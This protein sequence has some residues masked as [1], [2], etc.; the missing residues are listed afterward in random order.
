[1]KHAIVYLLL[2][3]LTQQAFSQVSGKLANV[4]GQ[5]IHLA[6]VALLKSQDSV[7]M[8][9]MLSDD[10]GTFKLDNVAGGKYLLKISLIGYTDWY[11]PVFELTSLQLAK[12]FGLIVMKETNKQL[13]EV[14]I[15]ADKPIVEQQ[16]GGLVVNVQ[17]SILTKGSSVLQLLERSPG[18]IINPQNN[19]ITLNG[20]GGVMVMIDGKLMRMS[21]TQI[22]AMLNGMSADNI[23]K[24]ELLNTPPAK[25]DA[26]GNAGLIN[27]VTKKNKKPGTNGSF[28]ATAG[29]GRGEKASTG[30]NISHNTG[31]VN[32]RGSYSYS[33]ER[34]YGNLFAAG[35]ESVPVIGGQT[36]FNYTGAGK[37]V[38]DYHDAL[39]GID[40]QLS[41]KTTIGGGID[42]AIGHDDNK[43]YN[44]GAYALRPD[45]VLLF[46][47]HLHSTNRSHNTMG[48]IYLDQEISKGEKIHIDA[49][50]IYYHN[51][52]PTE[53][54]SSFIDNRGNQAGTSDSLY[55]PKQ[56]DLAN[57]RIKVSVVKA[58]Y[59][60]QI[61]SKLK[62]E[63]GAKGTY[64]TSSSMS[65]IENFIDGKWVSSIS[66]SNNLGTKE[67]IG[68]GYATISAQLDTFTNLVAGARYEYSHNSTEHALSAMYAVDRRLGKLFPSIFLSRK[69]NDHA[70]LQ[71]S[72]TERISRPSYSDLASY[73]TYNDP[74]SVFTGN[75]ALKPT[76]THNLKLGYNYHSYLFSL[77][78]SR[79]IDPILQTQISTG[80]SKG[81]VYLAPQNAAWQNN[82]TFQATIPVKINS[83]WDMNY[84]FVGGLRQYKITYTPTPFEKTYLGY[85]AD[86]TQ[87][88]KLPGSFSIEV[89]GYY[90]SSA[91]YSTSR[92]NGNGVLNLGVKKELGNNKG[93]FQ[94]SVS[95]ILMSSSYSSYIGSLTRDAFNS[96]VFVR[97]NP[98]S[99]NFPI[100]KLTYYRSFGSAKGKSQRSEDGTKEER[101]RI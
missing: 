62:L 43:P 90:N 39:A 34:S 30:I 19:N 72:Y 53:V 64:T 83:W 68:A 23:E 75:P 18:V 57:T 50:Y 74:V 20:K 91:Y 32:L 36:S 97:Y 78:F 51:N 1:M 93:S 86:V 44:H 63:A 17:N 70:E 82:L 61:N 13:G 6:S 85:S 8:K 45:S 56:R 100:I 60:K 10:K 38:S 4:T 42:Y 101:S 69:L 22:A 94:L 87:N 54:Q 84:G 76:I 80:P 15:R 66:I 58:D 7:Q 98:E 25:Y 47:S 5:P 24:I 35:T 28:T 73:V 77:L 81:L 37:T 11:S 31:K 33:H 2:F 95:D 46:N 71:L 12:D 79:D 88:F 89:S 65:G 96:Q 16:A 49:D 48:N 3:F 41:P 9:A 99:R 40:V 59:T 55:A 27:I 21:M 14:V 52:S 26:D 29:Y 92:S 67:V